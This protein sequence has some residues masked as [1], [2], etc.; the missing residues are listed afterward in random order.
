MINHAGR[1]I[2]MLGKTSRLLKIIPRNGNDEFPGAYKAYIKRLLKSSLMTL[3]FECVSHMCIKPPNAY[4]ELCTLIEGVS[5]FSLRDI[6]DGNT[7][8]LAYITWRTD[9]SRAAA[10]PS[11]TVFRIHLWGNQ[12][13]KCRCYMSIYRQICTLCIQVTFTYSV[14]VCVFNC[15]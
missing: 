6:S 1:Y 3:R 5:F 4:Y 14:Y 8:S 13:W 7:S 15:N 12:K 2:C 9:A 10:R 11:Q